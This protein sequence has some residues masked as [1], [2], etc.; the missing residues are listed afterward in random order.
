MKPAPWLPVFLECLSSVGRCVTY[1]YRVRQ[2]VPAQHSHK[3]R[4]GLSVSDLI[5]N[6]KPGKLIN[7]C[8]LSATELTGCFYLIF[9]KF[10]SYKKGI[11]CSFKWFLTD[12]FLMVKTCRCNFNSGTPDDG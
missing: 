8:R 9:I 6:M 11:S 10:D 1:V 5:A 12:R 4:S 3:C 7:V 2:A